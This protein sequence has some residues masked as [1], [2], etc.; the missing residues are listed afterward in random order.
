MFSK[1]PVAG[2]LTSTAVYHFKQ[3]GEVFKPTVLFFLLDLFPFTDLLSDVI[4][5]DNSHGKRELHYY[6]REGSFVVLVR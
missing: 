6:G 3:Q 1:S 5:L 2:F 4:I